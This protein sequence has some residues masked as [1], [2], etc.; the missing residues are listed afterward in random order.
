MKRILIAALAFSMLAGCKKSSTGGDVTIAAFPKHHSVPIKG[1]T[2]Y[3]KF[4]ATELPA[5][6]TNN[7]DLKINGE[8]NEAHVHIE[9]LRYGKYFLYAVGYDS[10]IS[11]PVM[12]GVKI[13]VKWKERKDELDIDIPVVE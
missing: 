13:S 11:A 5:D 10:T 6:P 2:V 3:V 7:Y 9:G 8:S 12:G 1:A 4:D